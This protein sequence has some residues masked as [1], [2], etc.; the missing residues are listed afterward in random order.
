MIPRSGDCPTCIRVAIE[1][2]DLLVIHVTVF[3]SATV[4][5]PV[6]S[7]PSLQCKP[8]TISTTVAMVLNDLHVHAHHQQTKVDPPCAGFQQHLAVWSII[9]LFF[10]TAIA[11]INNS[12]NN[13]MENKNNIFVIIIT[14]QPQKILMLPEKYFHI[15]QKNRNCGAMF[16]FLKR[17]FK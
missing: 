11:N 14:N 10:K 13:R 2:A 6:P 5:V 12:N 9:F 3:H 8:S 17:L 4:A 1:V 7:D 16:I 15:K